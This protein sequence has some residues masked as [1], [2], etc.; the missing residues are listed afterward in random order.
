MSA[1]SLTHRG[2]LIVNYTE[3]FMMTVNDSQLVRAR[4]FWTA[5]CFS[6]LPPIIYL[7]ISIENIGQIFFRS[8]SVHVVFEELTSSPVAC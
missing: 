2:H 5:G 1:T 6:Y 3:F 4:S 8:D 7:P